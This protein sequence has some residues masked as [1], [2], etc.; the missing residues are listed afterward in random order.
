MFLQ[1]K[2]NVMLSAVAGNY[3]ER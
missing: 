1:T 2:L 3:D